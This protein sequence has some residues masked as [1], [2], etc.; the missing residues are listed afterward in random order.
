MFYTNTT[1]NSRFYIQ[2]TISKARTYEHPRNVD[3]FNSVTVL[4]AG[5][6]QSILLHKEGS[7]KLKSKKPLTQ[8]FLFMMYLNKK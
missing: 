8:A 7:E 3:K 1:H 4:V 6:S 5:L 2:Y